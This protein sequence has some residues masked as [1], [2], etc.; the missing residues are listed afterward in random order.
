MDG[1]NGS[2]GQKLLVNRY[3]F[4]TQQEYERAKKEQ[5]A[6]KFIRQ[7]LE[8]AA[9]EKVLQIYNKVIDEKM[10]ETPVGLE[11]L[12]ELQ[13]HLV[14]DPSVPSERIHNI[15]VKTKVAE[16]GE[17]GLE[18][19]LE[20]KSKKEPPEVRKWHRRF[21]VVLLLVFILIAM[22][23]AM[24]AIL[25]TSDSVTILNYKEQIINQYEEWE[26]QLDE[27]EKA[28]QEYEQKYGI[29]SSQSQN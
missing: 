22:V 6:A 1:K 16:Q 3:E 7:K 13:T 21:G 23:I 2:N 27:R 17:S 9:P 29:D 4:E 12:R 8:F 18:K 15:P 11:F 20:E 19:T 10:F 28:I 14:N 5:A 24:F 25:G 26:T